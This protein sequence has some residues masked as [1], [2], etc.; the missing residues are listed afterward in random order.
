MILI[1]AIRWLSMLYTLTAFV[2]PYNSLGLPCPPHDQVCVSSIGLLV[3]GGNPPVF[4]VPNRTSAPAVP[5]LGLLFL[6]GSGAR[7]GRPRWRL[8]SVVA[9]GRNIPDNFSPGHA[10]AAL[11]VGFRARFTAARATGRTPRLRRSRRLRAVRRDPRGLSR[12]CGIGASC[13]GPFSVSPL[14]MLFHL[15]SIRPTS[16]AI[17]GLPSPSDCDWMPP[18]NLGLSQALGV[19]LYLHQQHGDSSTSSGR[20]LLQMS[21]VF[22]EFERAILLERIGAGLA[23]AKA[24]GKQLGRPRAKRCPHPQAP[25]QGARHGHHPQAA[26]LRHGHSVG[27]QD[28]GLSLNFAA[29]D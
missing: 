7:N 28:R 3:P 16:G 10:G 23:R 15:S 20:A 26:R 13:F 18:R 2:L 24:Q 12:A 4:P 22:A 8:M 21:G 19:D 17:A 5:P 14:A 1:K 27:A 25:Q 11:F 6:G 9:H 29:T